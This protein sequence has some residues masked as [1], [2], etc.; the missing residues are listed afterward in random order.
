MILLSIWYIDSLLIDLDSSGCKF[1]L[2]KKIN[3]WNKWCHSPVN[4]DSRL[5][6]ISSPEKD[7][8]I[9]NIKLNIINNVYYIHI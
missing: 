3:N 5:L 7:K 6:D 1:I 8:V 4:A 9:L 2:L